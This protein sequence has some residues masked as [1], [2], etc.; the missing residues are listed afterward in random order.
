[1]SVLPK[2]DIGG[3][4]RGL[5]LGLALTVATTGAIAA[6]AYASGGDPSWQPQASERLVKLPASYIKRSL[7]QDFTRSGLGQALRDIDTE[8]SFKSETLADLQA[9]IQASEGEVRTDISHQFLVEKREYIDLVSR[10]ID[11]R[12]KALEKKS[13]VLEG[14]MKRMGQEDASLTP[15]RRELMERQTTARA[16]F[17][18]SIS[19][20]DMELLEISVAPE[21]KYSQ[22]FATNLSA[23][24]SLSRAIEEHPMSR[25]PEVDGVPVT[26]EAYV[27]QLIADAQA[28]L[29][30]IGQE[31]TVL[32]YMAKLVALDATALSEEVSDAEFIDS[33][34]PEGES[35]TGAVKFFVGQ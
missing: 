9:A 30:L 8:I 31:E 18:T 33:D 13:D 21:S 26:R 1:M 22:Q 12:R 23:I 19:G 5:I 7:E 32:G 25:G 4:P 16:R 10:K 29:E 27:R 24:D 35:L 11:L 17:E 6:P 14:L 15:A 34:I 2:L 20:V 28:E 3:S